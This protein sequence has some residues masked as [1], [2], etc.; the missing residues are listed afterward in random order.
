MFHADHSPHNFHARYGEHEAAINIRD[1]SILKVY[2][3]ARARELVTEWAVIHKLKVL[4]WP[5][6]VDVAPETVYHEATGEP[7]PSWLEPDS[8]KLMETK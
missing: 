5:E 2:L 7:L 1:F 8:C 4:C 6:D 3:S